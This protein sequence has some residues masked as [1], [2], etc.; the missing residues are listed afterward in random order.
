MPVNAS[1]WDD[2]RVATREKGSR[3]GNY[4]EEARTYDLTRGASPTVVR[5]ASRFLGPPAGRKLLDIAGGTGNYARVFQARGFEVVVLDAEQAMAERSAR[6]VGRGR[7]VVGD[8]AGLPFADAAFD[9]AAMIH[10]VHLL[11]EPAA[12]LREARR[13]IGAGPLVLVDPVRENAPLF[14]QEYFGLQ[15][16]EDGRPTRADISA[17]LTDSG[18]SRVDHERVVYTD[19]ADGSLYA[20]H[21]NALQL[22]GP[23][24]LRNTTFWYQLDPETR[25]QG[26]E[27]LAHALRSGELGERVRNHLGIAAERGHETVFAAWP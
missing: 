7:Q 22:A 15:P 4:A 2:R 11:A 9:A 16:A 8:A 26:L 23:A 10:A 25:R 18:F 19:T 27:A 1:E 13:V 5:L 24:Y 3:P 21:T 12:A 20:L 6:K 17:L 14:V